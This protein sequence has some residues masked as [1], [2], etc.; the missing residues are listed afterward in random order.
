MS[1]HGLVEI[2]YRLPNTPPLLALSQLDQQ[3]YHQVGPV[4]PT[5]EMESLNDVLYGAFWDVQAW[6]LPR[7]IQRHDAIVYKLGFDKVVV[8]LIVDHQAD[9]RLFTHPG[10]PVSQ[11]KLYADENMPVYMWPAP[12]DWELKTNKGMR[13]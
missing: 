10:I 6:G 5:Q 4:F 2:F 1:V 8:M 3:D 7:Q 11:R 12:V 9:I 13:A